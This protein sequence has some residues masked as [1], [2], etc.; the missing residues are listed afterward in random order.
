MIRTESLLRLALIFLLTYVFTLGGTWNG[1]LPWAR[2]L[3]LGVIALG[4]VTWLGVRWRRGWT[5]YNTALDLMFV[6]WAVAFGL[7]LLTNIDIWRRILMGFWYMGLYIGL[8]YV[9]HD[10]IANRALK[11]DVLIDAF[12]FAALIVIFFGYYQM[13]TF[14]FD[15]TN[16][17]LPRPVSVFGNPNF[18]GAF[19]VVLLP[20]SLT[21]L[22]AVRVPIGRI[23]LV[24]YNL[25]VAVLLVATFSR[26]AWLGAAVSVVVIIGLELNQRGIT[27]MEA[28]R[29][30]VV[31]R[32]GLLI[33]AAALVLPIVIIASVFFVRSLGQ[34]GRSIGLRTEIWSSSVEIFAAQ[35]LTGQGLFSFGREF[36]ATQSMPPEK[37]HS[38]AHNVPLHIA[39]ELGLIGIAIFT[40]TGVVVLV[41]MRRTWETVD[42]S[43][44]YAVMGAIAAVAGYSVHHLLDVPSMLPVIAITGM[45][46]LV[47][48]T[49][50]GDSQPMQ[51]RWRLR[52]HSVGLVGLWS[53][54]FISGVWSASIYSDFDATLRQPFGNNGTEDYRAAAEDL[55]TV[56]NAD[57]GMTWYSNQQGYLYGLAAF[58]GDESALEPA[59]AAYQR[60]TE[61]DPQNAVA[62][63]NLAALQW[64]A[65]QT[66]AAIGTMRTAAQAAPD[67]WQ[68][69]F[70]LGIYAEETA[71]DDLAEAAFTIAA[72]NKAAYLLADWQTTP[73]RQAI[74]AEIMPEGLQA[75]VARLLLDDLGSVDDLDAF[76]NRVEFNPNSSVAN[77]V[78]AALVALA[79][80]DVAEAEA[81]LAVASEDADQ[82]SERAW[83]FY[84]RAALARYNGEAETAQ[85]YYDQSAGL[86]RRDYVEPLFPRGVDI[87]SLQFWRLSVPRQILPQVYYPIIVPL[88]RLLATWE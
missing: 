51:A 28:L 73:L 7:S 56:I 21:R 5:W 57:P 88:A 58:E 1:L 40:I 38:H 2:F 30:W 44:R 78:V 77:R 13:R 47:M 59:I 67:A 41:T 33:G 34:S 80:D 12:L 22:L 43:D 42:R 86:L 20:F 26:G 23:A 54:V 9:L 68:F 50:P 53:V 15:I 83:L 62:Q 87:P 76:Y 6:G 61:T 27:S 74:Y 4:V 31:K 45:M 19:L 52:G 25:L 49:V 37:P 79:L 39:A 64:Q 69:W 46:A 66:E 24:I 48:A 3:A 10:M 17:E 55:T 11:R 81:Y 82:D 70:N 72:S 32:R 85:H 14:S 29:G 71:D 63:A 84:G 35:P 16:L 18:L 36:M 60:F 65:G 75:V 8:W